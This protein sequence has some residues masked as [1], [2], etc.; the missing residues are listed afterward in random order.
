MPDSA[1]SFS[2]AIIIWLRVCSRAVDF[3]GAVGISNNPVICKAMRGGSALRRHAKWLWWLDARRA[4]HARKVF[5]QVGTDFFR[6][7]GLNAG[8]CLCQLFLEIQLHLP[9]DLNAL[10]LR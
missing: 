1:N 8:E 2:A 3:R 4:E 10:C 9:T 5:G 6:Q 7:A